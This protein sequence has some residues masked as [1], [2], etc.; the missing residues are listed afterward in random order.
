MKQRFGVS[1]TLVF[2][3]VLAFPV[4]NPACALA[5]S[6]E[7]PTITV[8]VLNLAKVSRSTLEK[9]QA[10]ASEIFSEAGIELKWLN[11]PCEQSEQANFTLRIIPK[12]FGSTRSTF[13]SDHLGFAA[14]SEDG[15][16]LATV[17]FDRVEALGKGGDLS[18]LLGLATAHEL[19]HLL[20]GPRA[21]VDGGIMRPRWTRDSLRQVHR[22]GFFRFSPEQSQTMRHRLVKSLELANRLAAESVSLG[23][24]EV[25]ER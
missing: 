15:G 14:V 20:L 6:T 5:D 11:C 13:R 10:V 7:G 18:S 16:D 17:F 4:L 12:L 21:H 3:G 25:T 2:G 1:A 23:P 19:G 9:G 24:R 8:K 22:G